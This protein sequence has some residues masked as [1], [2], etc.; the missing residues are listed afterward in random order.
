MFR[1]R[2][3]WLA[4]AVAMGAVSLGPV[5]ST[6]AVAASRGT[7]T[8]DGTW[9]VVPTPLD[10]RSDRRLYAVAAVSA[11]DAWAVGQTIRGTKPG[12]PLIEHWDGAVWTIVTSP[13][14]SGAIG[15]WLR[16]VS[17]VSATDVWAVGQYHAG[18]GDYLVLVEH[19]NGTAWKTVSSGILGTDLEANGVDAISA[20]DVWLVGIQGRQTMGVL[21]TFAAHWDGSTWTAV[22]TPNKR[23]SVD[24]VLQ[25]VSGTA[26]DDVW[27]VGGWSDVNRFYGLAEH[28]NGSAWSIVKSPATAF[29]ANGVAAISP[30]DAWLVS[31][32]GN[33]NFLET[34]HWDGVSWTS[35]SN[36]PGSEAD[37]DAISAAGPND[38]WL[39]GTTYQGIRVPLPEHWNGSAWTKV[40]TDYPVAAALE[41]H[42][43]SV[44]PDGTT[45]FGVGAFFKTNTSKA[46]SLALMW[47]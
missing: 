31:T 32:D 38:I 8:C 12:K 47:C 39:M 18:S 46:R 19:W 40:S 44:T 28:W 17:V 24:D 34:Q 10:K 2:L 29:V 1:R 26:A 9:H 37:G 30:A 41:M 35:T 5:G 25:A 27:A 20:T 13:L 14:P 3:G 15:G 42:G 7:Q 11:T 21:R 43:V 22:A 33:G 36:V 23:N 45:A 16:A 4:L 6:V